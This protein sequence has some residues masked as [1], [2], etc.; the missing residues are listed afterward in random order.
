MLCASGSQRTRPRHRGHIAVVIGE[1]S[2]L[3]GI[4]ALGA[5]GWEQV[6]ANSEQPYERSH[7]TDGREQANR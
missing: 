5:D 1:V 2:I 7:R 6:R 4:Y 3:A